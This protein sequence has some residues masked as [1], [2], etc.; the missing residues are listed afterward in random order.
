MKLKSFRDYINTAE[1]DGGSGQY[2]KLTADITL[3]VG[4]SWIPIGK[5][6]DNGT[7]QFRGTFDGAGHKI[8]GLLIN[9]AESTYRGLFGRI[10]DSGTVK[11]LT[12]E[13]SITITA[14]YSG[15]VAGYNA[16]TIDHC[17]S[18]V[19]VNSRTATGGIVGTCD[20][21]RVESDPKNDCV[22]GIAGQSELELAFC[23]STGEIKGGSAGAMQGKVPAPFQTATISKDP[24]NKAVV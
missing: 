16:G 6:G 18:N 12:I 5:G 14:D 23:Y 4:D 13:G 7:K 11:D 21:G 8:S 15:G 9:N 3:P 24:P 20:G 17:T 22:G 1:N 10:A 19:E 2:F